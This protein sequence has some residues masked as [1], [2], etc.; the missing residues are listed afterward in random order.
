MTSIHHEQA[1]S[2]SLL[3][4]S[5]DFRAVLHNVTYLRAMLRQNDMWLPSPTRMRRSTVKRGQGHSS[6]TRIWATVKA[7][8]YGHGVARVLSGLGDVDGPAVLDIDDL[9]YRRNAGWTGPMMLYLG[10]RSLEQLEWLRYL[11]DGSRPSVWLRFTGDTNYV[12]FDAASYKAAYHLARALQRAGSIN[13]VGHMNHYASAQDQH[14]MFASHERFAKTIEGLPGPISTC[15][16]GAILSCP[17][18]AAETNWVRPGL[19]LK[20]GP[21]LGLRPAM[22]LHSRLVGVRHLPAGTSIGYD[23]SFRTASAMRMG[24]VS[25]GYAF[26]YPRQAGTGTPVLVEGRRTRVLGNVSMDLMAVDLT[27]IPH[28][29][30]RTP[31]LSGAQSTCLLKGWPGMRAPFQPRFSLAYPL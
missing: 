23:E 12:G 19:M 29:S 25:C 2:A 18:H 6:S 21:Q 5:I 15:N 10:L 22:S 3:R 24:L 20:T 8:A 17:R 16:S 7:N 31:L 30:L 27:P 11:P 9:I 13:L 4:A 26:G 28:A 1:R 14:E